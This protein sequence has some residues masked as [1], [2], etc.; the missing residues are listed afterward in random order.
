MMQDRFG[1]KTWIFW[2]QLLGCG[3]LGLFGVVFGPL[4][5]TGTLTDANGDVAPQAGPPLTIIGLCLLTVALLAAFNIVGRIR[6]IIRCYREGIE[7]NLVGATSLDGVPLVPGLVRVAWTI[8]S[9]QG[10]RSQRVRTSWTEFHGAQVSG[11]PMAYVLLLNG[12]FTNLE[13]GPVTHRVTFKQVAL[14]DHPERVA[15][16]LNQLAADVSQRDLLPS[17]SV[18]PGG[19][20]RGHAS[21]SNFEA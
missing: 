19:Q 1:G 14:A 21:V 11:I 9:L 5:W 12:S 2:A 15:G 10:F 3:G 17:W 4:F 18:S 7:C 13:S 8:L 20:K 6:P 16:I